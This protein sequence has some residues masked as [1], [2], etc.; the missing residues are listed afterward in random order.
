MTTRTVIVMVKVPRPGRVKTRLARDIGATAAARWS[1]H[2]TARLLRRLRDPRWQLVLSVS[3]DR[4]GLTSR[5][6][7]ADIP[8]LPQ[9]AGD[10]GDRMARALRSTPGPTL[11]VGADIPDLGKQQIARA[12]RALGDHASVLGPATDGGYWLVG[13]RHPSRAPAAMFRDVRWST[14][15]ALADTLP[16]LPAPVA[17]TDVLS[18]VD[19][20][21][22][23]PPSFW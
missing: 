11:L 21:A 22:D 19:T 8:R 1:R 12:F 16:T 9:G 4:E 17:R 5:I 13:L 14:R 18:A 23:L 6:W 2:Q 15:Y 10:L 20:V 7:P 3:P